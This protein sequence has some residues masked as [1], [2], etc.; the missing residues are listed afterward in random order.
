MSR[1]GK[2]AVAG[3]LRRLLHG[4]V[5]A[6]ASSAAVLLLLW[7]AT[8]FGAAA[9]LWIF[10]ALLLTGLLVLQWLAVRRLRAKPDA[11]LAAALLQSTSVTRWVY[12]QLRE[13]QRPAGG[14]DQRSDGLD[15][16]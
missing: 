4:A 1:R 13:M 16:D 6:G 7:L 9:M 5:A 3:A 12:G 10:G 11:E 14:R 8:R 2:P 15:D